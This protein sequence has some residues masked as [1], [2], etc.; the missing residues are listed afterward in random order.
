MT[1][2]ASLLAFTQDHGSASM[3]LF[4]H[5][6]QGKLKEILEHAME[7]GGARQAAAE[8]RQTDWELV[9][10]FGAAGCK[11]GGKCSYTAAAN[12][13]FEAN[14]SHGLRRELLAA[15]LR[16]VIVQGPSKTTRVP[17]IVGPTNTGKT[18]LIAPFDKVF[19][20]SRVMHKPALNARFALRNILKD[21]RFLS[22]DDY[23]PVEYAQNTI[24]VATFL[25]LFTGQPISEEDAGG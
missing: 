15:A 16:N 9:Q 12:R 4:V 24:P 13:I 8:E 14:A 1:S 20:F 5:Q 6:Q 11:L 17:F 18:T 22:W 19:G 7:W 23:R 3:Q 10:S 2:K 21:K 25:S